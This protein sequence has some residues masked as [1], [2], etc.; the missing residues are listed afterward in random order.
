MSKI[1]R[2]AAAAALLALTSAPSFAAD[3]GD[4][5][6]LKDGTAAPASP[7]GYSFTF[8]GTS[9]YVFRGFSQSAGD[10]TA[11]ASF[12]MNYGMFYAGVWG[13][14]IDFGGQPKVNGEIDF[15]AGIKPTLGKLNF[16]L[17]AIWYAYPGPNRLA[18]S[19]GDLDYVELKAG[20]STE[21][22]KN[23]TVSGTAFWTPEL[24]Y[25]GGQVWTFEGGAAY[26][27][28]AVGPF[29]PTVSGLVG[30][31]VADNDTL[32]DGDDSYVYW[33]IGLALAVD[34]FTFDFRYWDTDMSDG[35]CKGP[36]FQCSERFVFSAK[37]ALP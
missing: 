35:F 8:G 7:F 34:K 36:A 5:G 30:T 10:P 21:V 14:G 18:G 9:D 24:S 17:G 23:L 13:S 33:N 28:P 22:V 32:Y 11:Q 31:A 27:L 20:V 29:T 3:L 6:S 16:D 15:Y 37:I 26:Q 2:F 19:T 12:D 4:S 25:D 1:Y